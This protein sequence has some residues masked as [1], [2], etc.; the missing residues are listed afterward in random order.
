ME[1]VGVKAVAQFARQPADVGVHPG[2]VDGNVRVIDPA[3]RKRGRH[4]R[5]SVE[6][7]L[8]IQFRAVL[9]AVPNRAQGEHDLAQ[10]GPRRLPLHAVAALVVALDLG[11]EPQDE[12]ARGRALQI[13]GRIGQRHRATRKRQRN[14][15]SELQSVGGRGGH[16]Q[17]QEGVVLVLH[18]PHATETEVFGVAGN[19]NGFV[20]RTCGQQSVE[21]HG[22]PL[23]I[24]WK[25]F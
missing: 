1:R 11:A 21:F 16:C 20:E 22:R 5:V 12:A 6:L 13:P 19:R 10:L 3:W 9:P 14:R 25:G 24:P 17:R 23:C 4:E 8:K 18:A 2:D 7:A 15:G